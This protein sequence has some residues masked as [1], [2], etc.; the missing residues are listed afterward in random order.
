M[1][2][3]K[4]VFSLLDLI[5]VTDGFLVFASALNRPLYE[6]ERMTN[7]WL[8]HAW[9]QPKI[10]RDCADL[11]DYRKD[12]IVKKIERLID[13]FYP[14]PLKKK[15]FK[16]SLENT[17]SDSSKG[18]AKIAIPPM[19]GI[20]ERGMTEG[21]AKERLILLRRLIDGTHS[22]VKELALH[23]ELRGEL[24]LGK[25]MRRYSSLAKWLVAEIGRANE[26]RAGLPPISGKVKKAVANG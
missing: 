17:T 7:R 8:V 22:I 12:A 21:E 13:L 20:S 24:F 25:R 10:Q 1:Q 26:T 18:S 15:N 6:S 11:P 19:A 5:K 16:R 23:E 2:H 4:Y 9:E 3:R 14:S